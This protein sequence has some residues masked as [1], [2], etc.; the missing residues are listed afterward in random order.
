M[1][2]TLIDVF[3]TQLGLVPKNATLDLPAW[4]ETGDLANLVRYLANRATEAV[5][6]SMVTEFVSY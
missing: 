2:T 5:A 6:E 4:N 3:K 1:S